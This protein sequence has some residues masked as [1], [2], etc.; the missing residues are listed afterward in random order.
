[1]AADSAEGIKTGSASAAGP[2]VPAPEPSSDAEPTACHGRHP[3][4]GPSPPVR[5]GPRARRASPRPGPPPP[6]L[7]PSDDPSR[8]TP[9]LQ[10]SPRPLAP[11]RPSHCPPWPAVSSR[12]RGESHR[13]AHL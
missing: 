10:N 3:L 9:G 12:A 13:N 1:M 11:R 8:R 4:H 5:H 2:R 7:Q 6:S